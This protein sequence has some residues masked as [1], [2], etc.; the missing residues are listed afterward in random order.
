MR[1]MNRK[2]DAEIDDKFRII[3]VPVDILV[4]VV[5]ERIADNERDPRFRIRIITPP[6]TFYHFG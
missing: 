2:K 3:Q 4:D 6:L 5:L 1:L